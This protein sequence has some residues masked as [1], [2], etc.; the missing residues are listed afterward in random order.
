MD[1]V[2]IDARYTSAVIGR[3]G[4]TVSNIRDTCGVRVDVPRRDEIGDARTVRIKVTGSS[5]DSVDRAMLMIRQV[6]DDSGGSR[7]AATSHRSRDYNSG[8]WESG[9]GFRQPSRDHDSVIYFRSF[10]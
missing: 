5:R 1:Y 6:A 2:E 8:G 9:S 4:A 10:F 3:Q 7:G